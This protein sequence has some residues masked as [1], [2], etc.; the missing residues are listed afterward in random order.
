MSAPESPSW[1]TVAGAYRPGTT[2]IVWQI[3]DAVAGQ[4]SGR[5]PAVSA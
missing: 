2:T 3:S 1:E 5:P 4:R